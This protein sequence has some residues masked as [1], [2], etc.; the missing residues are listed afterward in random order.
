MPSPTATAPRHR[1]PTYL[2]VAAALLLSLAVPAVAPTA[3]AAPAQSDERARREEIRQQKAALAA[4]LNAA[5]ATD[6]QLEQAVAD[7]QAN[8]NAEQARVADARR[9]AEEA[10]AEADRLEAEV[11]ATQAEVDQLEEAARRRAV[12]SYLSFGST[13]SAGGVAGGDLTDGQRRQTLLSAVHG[14]EQDIIDR[15]GGAR[16][17]LERQQGEVADLI[18]EADARTAEV[19]QRLANVEAARNEKAQM[20]AA[21]EQRISSYRAEVDALSAEEAEIQATIARYEEQARQQAAQQAAARAAAEQQAATRATA[22]ASSSSS[23]SGGGGSSPTTGAANPGPVG[24]G[25]MVWPA[26]GAFTSGYGQRWGRLHAGIDIAAPVGTP[27]YAARSG[28]VISASMNSGGYGNLVLID[29]GGGI[30]T[31]YAHQS[32]LA[33]STGASVSA[34]QVIGYVGNTGNSTGPHLH[35]EVRV[36]GSAVNPMNYL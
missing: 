28:T 14:D 26:N 27:I 6:A 29:H 23:S 32:R 24:S 7:L 19:E 22:P 31:A 4:D 20:Q 25:G 2:A 11:A 3:G 18:A 9:A 33:T 30:V 13:G 21:L 35:F 15:L 12:E 10:R 17:Q 1:R 8:V 36:N 16:A 34:G 5:T